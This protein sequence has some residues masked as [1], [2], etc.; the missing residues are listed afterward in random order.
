MTDEPKK[1]FTHVAIAKPTKRKVTLL[2]NAMDVDIY[3]LVELWAEKEWQTALK[4]GLVTDAMLKP[5]E[6]VPA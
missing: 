1:E 4:A 6:K 3:S 5:S 2:A